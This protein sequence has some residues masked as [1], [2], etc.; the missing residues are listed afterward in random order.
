MMDHT[1]KETVV[2]MVAARLGRYFPRSPQS[3][4]STVVGDE[5]DLLE[6]SRIRAYIPN[7]VQHGARER[8]RSESALRSKHPMP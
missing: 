4:I 3:Q 1:E 8:L 7:L 6:G 2:S 5:Y